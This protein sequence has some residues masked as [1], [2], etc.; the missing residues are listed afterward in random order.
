MMQR[1]IER[2]A[3]K[4]L[5]FGVKITNTFPV[6]IKAGELPGNEMYMS[7]RALY[8]LSISLAAKLSTEFGGKLRISYSG[9]IDRFNIE[10]V[11]SCGI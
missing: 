9:G 2:S 7:G 3:A 6:E 5:E 8:A 4:D 1:L 10:K 11:V